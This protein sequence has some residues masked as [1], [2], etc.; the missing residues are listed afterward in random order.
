MPRKPVPLDWSALTSLAA[1][2]PPSPLPP[3]DRAELAAAVRAICGT[4]AQRHPG[5]QVE[6]RVP[7]FAAVQIALGSIGTHKRGTP[8]NVVEMDSSTLIRLAVGTL[9][10]DDALAT[11][12]VQASG[13]HSDLAAV[14]PLRDTD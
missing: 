11:Q 1:A 10:W 2:L 9:T 12:L 6:L 13:V 3:P 7:P 5:H 8:P 4:I 14:F